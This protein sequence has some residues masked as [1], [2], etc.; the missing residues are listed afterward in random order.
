M[1]PGGQKTKARVFAGRYRIG[2][3]IGSGGM[4]RVYR[5]FDELLERAVAVKVLSH[6]LSSD[7]R[8]VAR[9]RREAQIAARLNHPN[10]VSLYDYGVDSGDYFI[11]MELIDGTTV[12]DLIERGG[13]LEPRRAAGVAADVA[14]ALV[15][16]HEIGLVH[17]DVTSNNVMITAKGTTKVTDFGIARALASDGEATTTRVGTV[18]GTAAYLSPE[19]A[20][21]LPLD[22]RSDVYSLG[23]VLFEMLTGTVPFR[24]DTPL[25][26][27]GKHV[28]EPAPPPSDR[29]P[30]VPPDLDA[31]V[32][33]AL[34][35]DPGARFAGAVDM[36]AD[37][38]RFLTGRA[39]RTTLAME[40]DAV[41]ARPL[42]RWPYT[43]KPERG[44]SGARRVLATVLVAA[45]AAAGGF[46]WAR[47]TA[48]D[49]IPNLEGRLIS[50]A[51][52]RLV[53][54][55][56]SA[57]VQE[58]HGEEPAGIVV[59]QSPRAGTDM[60]AGE[61]VTLVVSKGPAPPPPEP[62]SFDRLTDDVE[63]I[64]RGLG[65]FLGL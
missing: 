38:T 37:L 29:T 23:V 32:V 65:D 48:D 27:A 62:G 1:K 39:I 56:L 64:F 58:Q 63:T 24:G 4:S 61:T 41:V 53:E 57:R 2:E 11:V 45:I 55:G 31:I 42:E 14:R 30:T 25:A 7:D 18:L 54:L 36:E 46:L 59:G 6:E 3:P 50:D 20:Q 49:A 8:F 21:G 15:S 9:F 34:A 43:N 5:G 33:R 22:P 44:P 12:A 35:K 26:T 16:A 13:A 28:T 10:V 52:A 51:R 19:Q 17:R 60:D 47:S 40:S